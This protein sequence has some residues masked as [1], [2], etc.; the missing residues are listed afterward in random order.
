MEITPVLSE[1]ALMIILK[2]AA[3]FSSWELSEKSDEFPTLFY[4]LP[5]GFNVHFDKCSYR[6]WFMESYSTESGE[7]YPIGVY[8]PEALSD[9]LTKLERDMVA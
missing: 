1:E 2:M 8:V 9:V 7:T 3:D 6:K 4:D 5:N